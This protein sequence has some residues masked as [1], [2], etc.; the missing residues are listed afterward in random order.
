MK[1]KLMRKENDVIR[2]LDFTEDKDEIQKLY[3]ELDVPE[4]GI[5]I[6][7]LGGKF[8]LTTKKNKMM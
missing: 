2:I 3:N 4:R 1:N 5:K 8:K 7:Y 6:E